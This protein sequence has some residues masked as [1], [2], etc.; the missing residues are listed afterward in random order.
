MATWGEPDPAAELEKLAAELGGQ[1]YAVA[2][3][4]GEGRRPHL[5]ITNRRAMQLTEYVYSDGEHFYWA[6]RIAPV[7]D[8]AVAATAIDQVLQLLG[9]NR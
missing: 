7:A 2:L 9:G 3:V 5:H 8:L 4:T 1:T 6:E